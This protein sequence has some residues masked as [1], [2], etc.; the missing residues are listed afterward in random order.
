MPARKQFLPLPCPHQLEL[1]RY[2]GY[3]LTF[4]C[5]NGDGRA[6][7]NMDRGK[8]VAFVQRI[9]ERCK[10]CSSACIVWRCRNS[11]RSSPRTTLFLVLVIGW[12]LSILRLALVI[13]FVLLSGVSNE[14]TSWR[15]A[16][17]NP[18]TWC[19]CVL[20]RGSLS[21]FLE[22]MLATSLATDE[23]SITCGDI[24]CGAFAWSGK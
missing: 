20:W 22:R 14:K 2:N 17:E 7:P 3:L 16:C 6:Q 5:P 9:A 11:R 15:L 10:C 21:W 18:F 8:E 1:D 23:D 24:H 13:F 19:T 4:Q 12:G